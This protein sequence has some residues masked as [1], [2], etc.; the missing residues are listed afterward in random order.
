MNWPRRGILASHLSHLPAGK[1]GQA[2]TK[3]NQNASQPHV[4]YCEST[5]TVTSQRCICS[6]SCDQWWESAGSKFF[7]SGRNG[8]GISG[9]T[10]W[11]QDSR[12]CPISF[13]TRAWNYGSY[14]YEGFM[15]HTHLFT[16]YA[17]RSGT[18]MRVSVQRK[19][20]HDWCCERSIL[21]C[22]GNRDVNWLKYKNR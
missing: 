18:W 3:A 9:Y 1:S 12:S 6:D 5:G 2:P 10:I 19:S 13:T 7:G 17:R 22:D 8:M 21:L 16:G 4:Q 15:L 20:L 14:W 11:L